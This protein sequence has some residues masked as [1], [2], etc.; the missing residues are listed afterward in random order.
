MFVCILFLRIR[1]LQCT[2]PPRSMD[3][4]HRTF[5]LHQRRSLL[6]TMFHTYNIPHSPRHPGFQDNSHRHGCTYYRIRNLL[7]YM[8]FPRHGIFRPRDIGQRT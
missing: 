5:R 7:H 2:Y 6:I 4:R 3:F 1:L 8:V